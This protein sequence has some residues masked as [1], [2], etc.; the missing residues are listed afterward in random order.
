MQEYEELK[1]M[2][3]VSDHE[4]HT[5]TIVYL[6]HQA[7]LKPDSSSTKVRV[8]FGASS[9]TS[10]G[11]SLNTILRIG[12]TIQQDLFSTLLRFR[13]PQFVV[14]ADIKQMYRQVLLQDDQRD[15]QRI[16]WI[17]D[18]NEPVREYRL[19]TV[20]YGMASAP[21][22]AIRCLHQLANENQDKHP[23]ASK[24]IREDFY[25]DDL[26]T[27]SDE[28]STLRQLKGELIEIL[29]SAGFR[30][31]KWNT[32]EPS[33]FEGSTEV[34]ELPKNEETKTLGICWN[35]TD[36]CLQYRISTVKGDQRATKRTVLLTI[37]QIFDPLGLMGPVT[38]RTKIILQQ[39]WQLKIGWDESLPM[40]LHTTWRQYQEQM[41]EMES[42]SIPRHVMCKNPQTIELHG[43]CD[44]S[45]AAY[46]ACIFIRSINQTGDVTT[47]LL[48]A[49][50]RVAPLKSITL[51]RLELCGTLLLV[52]LG[53]MVR[54]ALPLKFDHIQYWSDSTIT[55]AW[56]KHRPGEL[57]TFVANRVSAIQCTA[58]DVQ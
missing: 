33:I 47:R 54:K 39:L 5:G 37:A 24:V 1:H 7:V 21:F 23:E 8:V 18:A 57:Q 53:A 36:D 32:N 38:I 13:Q 34:Q 29:Q 48:C 17:P 2:S 22:L 45:E 41:N 28:I 14:T 3:E 16:V 42:I 46:G 4:G 40:N 12:P 11:V 15:L 31:H 27:G 19:N 26:L 30:L 9:P 6:P 43:F 52:K 49:K 50:S 10:T 51:P 56:I 35:T 25:V 20:T 44:A 58:P 55:L